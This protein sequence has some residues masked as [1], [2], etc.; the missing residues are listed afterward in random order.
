MINLLNFLR[1]LASRQT[2]RQFAI[3]NGKD[4]AI[5]KFGRQAVKEL[6]GRFSRS[7]PV[8]LGRNVLMSTLGR[9]GVRPLLQLKNAALPL[10]KTIRS[11]PFIGSILEF[12]LRVFLF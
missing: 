2:V 3:E 10:L 5:R 4:A 6:G 12:L 11:I 7:A 1:N 9:K 8:N